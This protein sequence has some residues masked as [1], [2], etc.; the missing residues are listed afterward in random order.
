MERAERMRQILAAKS[1]TLYDVSRQS[2]R[3]FGRSSRFYVPHNLYSSIAQSSFSPAIHQMLA[4]SRIT[5]Y[6]LSNWLA[7]FGFDLDAITG[8]QFRIPRRRTALLDSSVYDTDSWIPWFRERS[9][10]GQ[11]PAIAPLGSLVAPS[12]PRRARELPGR[13]ASRFLYAKVGE[14]DP[15]AF[16][17]FAPGSIVRADTEGAGSATDAPANGAAL[18][19]LIEYDGGWTCAPLASLGKGRVLLLAPQRPCLEREVRLGSEARI[20]GAI[21]AEIRPTIHRGT[22]RMAGIAP[23]GPQPRF[24]RAAGHPT[25]LKDVLRQS[26]LGLGLSFRDAS[27]QTRLI[28]N[29]LSEERYFT[30]AST[31]SDYETL[32]EPPKHVHKILT[33]CLL[34]GLPFDEFLRA[35]GL[36]LDD[37]GSEPMPDEFVFGRMSGHDGPPSA[38]A[39]ADGIGPAGGFLGTL[40]KEWGEVPLFLRQSLREITGLKDLSLF[41]VFW[42]GGE[43]PPLHPW[44]AG[45]TLAAVNRR[46]KKPPR[47][48]KRTVC[49]PSLYI[50]LKRGGEFLCGRTTL[51][52]E[53]LVVHPYPGGPVGPL[54]FVDGVDAELVGQ[55]VAIARHLGN[56]FGPARSDQG[57]PREVS[58]ARVSL[59][60]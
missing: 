40:L 38:D 4:L 54:R 28:A 56:R 59:P 48:R 7:V 29:L 34:Y 53:Q 52:G 19:F 43:D 50:L 11:V 46:A 26:R 44:L 23:V 15:Y 51:E 30:A 20:L 6:R 16:P 3:M 21:D 39:P 36:P 25:N 49:E 45:A 9:R 2:A 8:L 12:A 22:G 47:P 13:S 18:S 24:E 17:A 27:S 58:G 37:A 55:V 14:E 1:T 57:S 31:L 10:A 60:P 5:N 33:L 42:V 41:D 32:T 35:C